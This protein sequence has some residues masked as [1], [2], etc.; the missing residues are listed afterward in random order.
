M[1]GTTRTPVGTAGTAALDLNRSAVSRY[2]Q[3]ATLFRRRIE[4]G[5]WKTGQQIPRWMTFPQNAAWH[6][7]PFARRSTRS[8]RR[9]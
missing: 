8:R 9:A 3:L 6:A 5:V 1:D 4:Q 7:P 2:I